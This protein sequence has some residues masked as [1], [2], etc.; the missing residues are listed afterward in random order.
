MFISF[1]GIFSI[2]RADAEIHKVN[3]V[4]AENVYG[5]VAKQ[6]GGPYV[7]VVNVLNNPNQDPHMFSVTPSTVKAITASDI[8]I[9]NGADYDAWVKPLLATKSKRNRQV[10]V[11]ADLMGIKAGANPHIWYIPETIPKFA[12]HL[13]TLL[14]QYN[15]Q[16]HQYFDQQ[17]KNFNQRYSDIF[18]AVKQLNHQFK[19]IPV[20]ATEPV[21]NYMAQKIGLKMMGDKFQ[22]SIMN[23]EQ[24]SVFAI[25]Q[26]EDD[27]HHHKVRLLIYNNQV[28]NPLTQRMQ[29]IAKQEGIPVVGVSEMLPQDK[30]YEQWMMRE[31][32]AVGKALGVGNV[33]TP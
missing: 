3:I 32:K 13:V 17:L 31:L 33:N 11:V 18:N 29:T 9:Y 7:T 22:E 30:T 25:Q 26:F 10:I 6:L 23:D 14:K 2:A 21:F 16:Y 15:P 27:L 24:P 1:Y 28:S 20:I 5:E 4:S 19:G 8:V 12:K